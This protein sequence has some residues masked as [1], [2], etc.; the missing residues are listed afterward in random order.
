MATQIASDNFNRADNSSTGMNLG[1]NWTA[2]VPNSDLGIISNTAYATATSNDN[3]AFWN[4]NTF[5]TDQY[6]EVTLSTAGDN[7][8]LL[9][10]CN[11]SDNVIG[12]ARLSNTTLSIFWYN[13]STY[14]QI[15][16]DYSG[17]LSNSDVIRLEVDGPTYTFYQ[18]GVS[19]VTGTN[20]SAPKSGSPGLTIATSNS[21]L[22]S[23]SGGNLYDNG[24]IAFTSG[25]TDSITSGTYT[26]ALTIPTGYTNLVLVAATRM[27]DSTDADRN[28][29]GITWNTSEVLVQSREDNVDAYD[30]TTEQWRLPNPTTGTH[31]AVV[32]LAG[33][34][35]IFTLTLI[36]LAG[37]AQTGLPDAS[38]GASA[39]TGHPSMSVTTA[40]NNCIVIDTLYTKDAVTPTPGS[41]QLALHSGTVNGGG[42][43]G[44][45]S[46]ER[47]ATAGAVTMSWTQN[48]TTEQWVM[49]G[50][51]YPVYTTSSSIK[52][53]QGLAYASVK[54][55][56]GLAIASMKTLQGLA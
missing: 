55:M 33:S 8:G 4:A 49:T 52:T 48:I 13:S 44:G 43:G 56:N 39:A 50:V 46:Y 32:T 51:S 53:I 25:T 3:S 28:I 41:G 31:N 22:D 20:A 9:V 23:W 16:S 17:G 45:C 47:K 24:I 10:R 35:G 27:R 36:V 6:A 54:T 21:R 11:A 15:G 5:H 29:T 18:N 38:N 14:T 37:T 2:S 42:D 19:R 1:S 34:G 30:L 26:L 7:N 12:Q 40:T